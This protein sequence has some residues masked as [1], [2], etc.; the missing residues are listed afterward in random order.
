MLGVQCKVGISAEVAIIPIMLIKKQA[1]FA[2][3]S[4]KSKHNQSER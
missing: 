4:Y 3:E 1:L 2:R